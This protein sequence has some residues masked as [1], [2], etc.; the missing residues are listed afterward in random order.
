MCRKNLI[1]HVD[2]IQNAHRIVP[3]LLLRYRI[4]FGKLNKEL[5]IAPSFVF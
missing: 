5:I 1:H 2:V 3:R 4:H